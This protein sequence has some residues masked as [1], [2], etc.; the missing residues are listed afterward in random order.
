MRTLSTGKVAKRDNP[1]SL[2]LRGR[3]LQGRRGS[4]LRL[5]RDE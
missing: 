3:D 5:V 2:A 4:D 1:K